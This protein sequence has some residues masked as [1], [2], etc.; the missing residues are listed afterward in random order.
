MMVNC[1]SQVVKKVAKI[2]TGVTNLGTIHILRKLLYSTKLN[3]ISKL[4]FF[5]KTK[6]YFSTLRSD[7]ID[8][9]I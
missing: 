5:V 2:T 6:E 8:D 4:G 9:V 7:E 3:L 1:A